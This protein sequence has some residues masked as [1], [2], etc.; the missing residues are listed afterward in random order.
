MAGPRGAANRGLLRCGVCV[1]SRDPKAHADNNFLGGWAAPSVWS[2]S[3]RRRRPPCRRPSGRGNRSDV[4]HLVRGPSNSKAI[5]H[6]LR[7][8]IQVACSRA[9]PPRRH[10]LGAVAES[11]RNPLSRLRLLSSRIL[12]RRCA[13]PSHRLRPLAAVCKY[14]RLAPRT[15]PS[16]PLPLFCPYPVSERERANTSQTG[17]NYF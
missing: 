15:S 3:A 6:E 10:L 9:Q 4:A 7:G 14:A 5:C 8:S 13:V 12:A 16:S 17:K 1:L 2:G 11:R